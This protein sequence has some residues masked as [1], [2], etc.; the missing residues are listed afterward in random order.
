[1]KGQ[2]IHL[3]RSSLGVVFLDSHVNS[4]FPGRDCSCSLVAEQCPVL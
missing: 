2:N 4:I 3:Q 1:M